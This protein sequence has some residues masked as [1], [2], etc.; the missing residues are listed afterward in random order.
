MLQINLSGKV[1]I[2]TGATGELGKNI[3]FSCARCKAKVVINYFRNKS[4]AQR[5]V[6]EIKE[7]DGQA[8]AIR[9]DVRKRD[10]VKRMVD[11]VL[12][13]YGRVDA[14]INNAGITRDR[15]L[16]KM[17]E[18]DWDEVLATNLKGVYICTKVVLSSML[19]N[20]RGKIINISSSVGLEGNTGQANYAASKAGMIGFTRSLAK[21]AGKYNVKANVICPG[22]MKSKMTEKAGPKSF[23]IAEEE[24]LLGRISLAS[25]VA[26]FVLFLLSPSGD[27][28][29]GQVFNID[30]RI[31]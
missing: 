12:R 17:E 6:D 29:T 19:K 2:V 7:R 28:I 1:I 26:D 18:K 22:F 16:L 5:M 23:R 31:V 24:S 4:F 20:R 27:N 13:E 3:A 9:A 8:L 10:Q 25:D 15:L 14:L 11:E 21:E 30:S